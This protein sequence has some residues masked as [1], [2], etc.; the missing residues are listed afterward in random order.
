MAYL[1]CRCTRSVSQPPPTYY[2]HLAAFRGRIMLAGDAASDAES[3]A[4]GA[5]VCRPSAPVLTCQRGPDRHNT[6]A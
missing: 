5:E 6:L 3:V 1:F 4:S 2:A